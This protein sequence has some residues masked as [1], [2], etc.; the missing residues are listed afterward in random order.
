MPPLW[1][2]FVTSN[3][4]SPTFPA[5]T[6]N[7]LRPNTQG[8]VYHKAISTMLLLLLSLSLAGCWGNEQ[9]ASPQGVQAESQ[10]PSQPVATATSTIPP[11]PTPSP[12]L[13]PFA[14]DPVAPVQPPTRANTATRY[15]TETGHYL[16]GDFLSYYKK[17][18]NAATLF[19]LPLTEEFARSSQAEA[20]TECNTSSA[21]G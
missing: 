14:G 2:N 9:P 17:T 16:G 19:G 15:Y 20:S 12:T 13:V 3:P 11:L 4:L 1:Y 8:R 10:T 21:P 7:V 18:P 6:E 5:I